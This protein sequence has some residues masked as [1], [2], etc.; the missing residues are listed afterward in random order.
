[1]I[2]HIDVPNTANLFV[3]PNDVDA[4]VDRLANIIANSINIALHPGITLADINKYAW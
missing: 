2:A 3:T 1:M 4:N